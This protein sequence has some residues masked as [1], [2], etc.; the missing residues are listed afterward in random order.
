[1]KEESEFNMIIVRSFKGGLFQASDDR[2]FTSI[3]E[4]IEFIEEQKQNGIN[5]RII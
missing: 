1:M 5:A 4:A 2:I 3:N